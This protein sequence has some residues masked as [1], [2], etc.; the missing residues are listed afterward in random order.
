MDSLDRQQSHSQGSPGSVLGA[1]T[2]TLSLLWKKRPHAIKATPMMCAPQNVRQSGRAERP[3]HSKTHR[4]SLP[5]YVGAAVELWD[6]TADQIVRC[7]VPITE[8]GLIGPRE[9][10]IWLE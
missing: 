7:Q 8:Y 9:L 1:G 5:E 6:S 2:V 3:S 4:F 10:H